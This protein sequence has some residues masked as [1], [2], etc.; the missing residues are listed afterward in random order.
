MEG[1]FL[2]IANVLK[3]V[4]ILVTN[5]KNLPSDCEVYS[6]LEKFYNMISPE[7]INTSIYKYYKNKDSIGDLQKT[8]VD[9]TLKPFEIGKSCAK[10]FKLVLG[11]DQEQIEITPK[12]DFISVMNSALKEQKPECP[13]LLK[14]KSDKIKELSEFYVKNYEK[15]QETKVQITTKMIDFIG[16]HGLKPL[17]AIAYLTPKVLQDVIQEIKSTHRSDL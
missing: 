14:S 12:A 17:I 9:K 7:G 5:L 10:L 11:W 3:E 4:N 15:I 8:L 13:D 1:N 6:V 2:A 16:K